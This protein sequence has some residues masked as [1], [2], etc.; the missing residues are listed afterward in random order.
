MIK[1]IFVFAFFIGILTI[2]HAQQ[3]PVQFIIQAQAG[4]CGPDDVPFWLRSNQ[5]GNIPPSG[6]FAGLLAGAKKEYNKVTHPKLDWGFGLEAQLYAGNPSDVL[7]I[8]AYGKVKYG[9]FQLKAGRSK[10]FTGLGDTLLSSGSWSISGN[11]PGIPKIEL[12]IPEFYTLPI[13][14]KLFAFKGNYVHG[15]MGNW[16]MNEEYIPNTGT[17][18]HQKSF[19]GKFGKDRWRLK[20]YGGFNHQVVWGQ[21]RETL[22]D[23]YDLSP[24]QT[25]MYVNLGKAYSRDSIQN[26]RLGNSLGSIDVGITYEFKKVRLFAYRQFTY[27]AGALFYLANLRDGLNG[28]SITNKSGNGKVQWNKLLLEFLYTKNQ[29]GET[30]S[31]KTTSPYENY[32]NNGYYPFGWSYKGLCLGNPLISPRQSIRDELP[33]SPLYFSNNRVIA[34][35]VGFELT[36]FNWNVLSKLSYSRNYG[37]YLTSPDGKIYNGP[38][39]EAL[40]GIFPEVNQFSGY[41]EVG[42]KLNNGIHL[43]FIAALDQGELLY[44]SFGIMAKI[45]KYF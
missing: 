37:V 45:A 36:L 44:N 26:T 15:W 35:H 8:E 10:D 32:Y 13:L 22:G 16:Y 9:I 12:S 29:A 14:G 41:L 38:N 11:A 3:K 2:T 1:H 7:L 24:F 31:P 17:Y 20:L 5:H 42:K 33:K 6:G 28:I 30:W 40:Y 23:S 39:T 4:Y 43:G 25:F 34:L 27:D 18:L 21:E 19:Y